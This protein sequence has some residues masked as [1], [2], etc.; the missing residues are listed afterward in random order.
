[1]PHIDWTKQF[2]TTIPYCGPI[3]QVL[4]VQ[5]N[6]EPLVSILTHTHTN[7]NYQWKLLGYTNF[8]QNVVKIS[9]SNFFRVNT[10][11]GFASYNNNNFHV[12]WYNFNQH[13]F[14]IVR[15]ITKFTRSCV[16]PERKTLISRSIYNLSEKRTGGNRPKFNFRHICHV[17]FARATNSIANIS[18]TFFKH[19][20]SNISSNQHIR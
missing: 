19:S 9:L 13:N 3:N 17:H 5:R 10:F 1:M 6:I 4:T 16:F 12:R 14:Y 18:K 20:F 15:N 7:T 2:S 8:K 11:A